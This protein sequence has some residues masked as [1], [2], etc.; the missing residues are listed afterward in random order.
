MFLNRILQQKK[1]E[2]DKEKIEF[3]LDILKKNLDAFPRRDFK[4]AVSQKDKVNIIAA[5]PFFSL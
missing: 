5:R 2:L 4:K 1:I 3:P